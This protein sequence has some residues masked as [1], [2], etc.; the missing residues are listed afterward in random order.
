MVYFID[1][2]I[3]LAAKVSLTRAEYGI[4]PNVY[5]DIDQAP[6]WDAYT[7]IDRKDLNSFY[8]YGDYDTDDLELS[9]RA[10]YD[11]YEDIYKIYNEPAYQSSWPAVTY[12]DNRLGTVIKGIKTQEDHTSTFIFQA[13]EN[14]HIRSGGELR[15]SKVQ[16]RYV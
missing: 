7:R 5:T 14:E 3:H 9:V 15:Y 13:E 16:S 10:Y 4:P 11:E 6:V 12:D 8:L 1:D 2:Q